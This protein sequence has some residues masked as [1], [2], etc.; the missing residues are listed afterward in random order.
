ML[1]KFIHS[2]LPA[3]LTLLAAS[4]SAGQDINMDEKTLKFID[5]YCSSCHNDEVQKGDVR[6]D[7]LKHTIHTPV[8]AQEWQDVLDVLNL[9]EM[10]PKKHKRKPVKQPSKDDMTNMIELLTN[11]M[12]EARLA[13]ADN[14][15]RLIMR[16]LN[17]REYQNAIGELLGVEVNTNSLP[18]DDQLNGFDTIGSSLSLTGFHLNQ[19]LAIGERALTQVTENAATFKPVKFDYKNNVSS[20][21][22]QLAITKYQKLID[23]KHVQ[24]P[25]LNP[26]KGLNKEMWRRLTPSQRITYK[27]HLTKNLVISKFPGID[28]GWAT[29]HPK[30][31]H[32]PSVKVGGWPAGKYIMKL[33]VASIGKDA[34]EGRF[35]KVIRR[36]TAADPLNKSTILAHVTATFDNPEI[37]EVPFETH[38]YDEMDFQLRC[39]QTEPPTRFPMEPHEYFKGKNDHYEEA[40]WVDWAEVRKVEAHENQFAQIFFK[41]LAEQSEVYA[42][43]IIRRFS[44]KA[45]RQ[46]ESDEDYL[47]KCINI[48]KKALSAGRSF[49]AAVKESLAYVLISPR[50]LYIVEKSKAKI[51]ALSSMELATRLSLFLWSSTP[52]KHLIE[53]AQN[54]SLQKHE[55]LNTQ[56]DRMLASPKA[57]A[58]YDGFVDQWLGLHELQNIAFPDKFKNGPFNSASRE[59][60]ETFK[61]LVENNLSFV[62]LLNSDFVVIDSMLADFYG[63]EGVKGD[64]F[65]AVKLKNGSVRGGLLGQ[66][67]ILAM[68]GD[69]EK[70]LPIKRGAFVVSKLLDTPPASPP[71]NVPLL[72]ADGIKSTR[73]LFEAH[74]QEAACASCHRRFDPM[75]FALENFDELGQWREHELLKF[76]TVEK[77]GVR[78]DVKLKI[79]T[80]VTIDASGVF[81]DGSNPFKTYQEMKD[82]IAE[83]KKEKFTKVLTK[84]IIQ[85]GIG[86]P[87]SFTDQDFITDI[88]AQSKKNGYK[89]KDFIKSIIFS[90]S[91]SHK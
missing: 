64:K 71:P 29:A 7:E 84:G 24:H 85:Y 26:E 3:T 62:N 13:M 77:D 87:V 60:I 58:F 15:S 70:S 27:Q 23:E 31:G 32:A 42:K 39:R 18:N 5:N 41:G 51:S 43:E 74:T 11:K 16:R 38:S 12:V 53:L 68:G 61:Y 2:L 81:E 9:G 88:I 1:K 79:P 55:V 63:I 47:N 67:G 83:A 20:E 14:G 17:K 36:S 30:A 37:I 44:K 28:T 50:F 45:F 89:S 80:K 75:G 78:K 90:K 22:A 86:R 56:I 59:P 66:V 35:L 57:E 54:N 73:A 65:R 91:F 10:P 25:G 21:R 72:K 52:D 40:V 4:L 8:D 46:H 76:K 34:E 49:E 82:L 33:R 6:L 69:G 48:Y 19:Y